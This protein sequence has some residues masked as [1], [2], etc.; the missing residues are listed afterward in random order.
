LSQTSQII[1]KQSSKI[2]E[3]ETK[4]GCNVMTLDVPNAFVQMPIPE[5]KEE[6]IMKIRGHLVDLLLENFPGL[7]DKYF[8]HEGKAKHNIVYV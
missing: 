1:E 8:V 3:S 7:Y 2:Q 5:N 4:Q 6:I